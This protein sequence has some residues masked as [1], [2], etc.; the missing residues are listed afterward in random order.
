MADSGSDKIKYG[1][2]KA[3]DVSSFK[4][5]DPVVRLLFGEEP[6]KQVK[7]HLQKWELK[8]IQCRYIA[9]VSSMKVKKKQVQVTM[10][11]VRRVYI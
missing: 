11:V 8:R 6:R 5:F 10:N 2:L 3:I 1:L 7:E 9:T 4:V